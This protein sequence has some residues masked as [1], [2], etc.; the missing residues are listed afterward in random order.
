MQRR[1]K[2]N[3]YLDI[4]EVVS[5]RGTCIRRRFG[6]VIVKHDEIISTGYVGAARG[7]KNCCELEFCKREKLQIPS[8]QRY[9]MCRSVHA[10]QNAVI[11]ASRQ[12]LLNSTL[13]LVCK[14]YKTGELTAGTEPCQMCKRVLINA[15]V[16][17]VY[18]RDT[19]DTYRK[20]LVQ[21]W[22]ENDDP[23][24]DVAGY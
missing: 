18:V 8:G 24:A 19:A 15:G 14:D 20:I 1:D 3:Y 13:Y 22:I 16:S 12:E 5:E 7:L 2:T 21:S 10:E 11:S 23:Y 9:E 4:A 17:E 6:A